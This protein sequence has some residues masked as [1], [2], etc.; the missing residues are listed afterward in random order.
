MEPKGGRPTDSHQDPFTRNILLT[1]AH[2]DEINCRQLLPCLCSSGLL[3]ECSAVHTHSIVFMSNLCS[4]LRRLASP[5]G[6]KRMGE[7]DLCPSVGRPAD[8]GQFQ[9]TPLF[10]RQRDLQRQVHCPGRGCRSLDQLWWR[11]DLALTRR[12]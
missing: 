7:A 3:S 4:S 10:I 6:S 2:V 11:Q 12:K 9:W 1:R 8:A 5:G